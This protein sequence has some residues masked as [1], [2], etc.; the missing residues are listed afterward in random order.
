MINEYYDQSE[1]SI[2]SEIISKTTYISYN[3]NLLI[4]YSL[5]LIFNFDQDNIVITI[6]TRYMLYVV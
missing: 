6:I 5:S 3:Y 2:T 1:F 4:S